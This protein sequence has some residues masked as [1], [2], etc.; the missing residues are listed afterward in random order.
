MMSCVELGD[1]HR[2]VSLAFRV[3]ASA[4][5]AVSKIP[6]QHCQP[7]NQAMYQGEGIWNPFTSKPVCVIRVWKPR[8][9]RFNRFERLAFSTTYLESIRAGNPTPPPGT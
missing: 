2:P 5:N 4:K 3:L 8:F 1:S 6:A 9:L 7:D